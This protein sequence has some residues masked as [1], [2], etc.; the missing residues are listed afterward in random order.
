[1]YIYILYVYMYY[2]HL[3]L[4]IYIYIYIGWQP[5]AGPAEQR[6]ARL[7]GLQS[8]AF[9]WKEFDRANLVGWYPGL[10]ARAKKHEAKKGY[11][12]HRSDG[13]VFPLAEARLAASMLDLTKYACVI[14]LGRG[15]AKAVGVK[16]GLLETETRGSCRLLVF[17]HPSGVSHF[18]NEPANLRRASAA[19]RAAL[20]EIRRA[21]DSGPLLAPLRNVPTEVLLAELA[22]RLGRAASANSS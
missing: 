14:L 8:P 12:L 9:L 19:L 16:V 1:M 17:P 18:W 13:D 21:V 22:R 7:A 3:S 20:C 6:L 10:K 5:L 2:T 15:V 4:S 11:T